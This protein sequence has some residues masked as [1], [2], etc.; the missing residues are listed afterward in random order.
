[1]ACEAKKF[2]IWLFIK[3]RLART[4]LEKK[5]APGLEDLIMFKI[6]F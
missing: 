1:M 3:E 6:Q 2:T 4:I 5:T